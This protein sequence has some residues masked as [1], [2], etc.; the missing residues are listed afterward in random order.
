MLATQEGTYY[1]ERVSTHNVKQVLN[2]K[3]AI[4][5]ALK[6]QIDKKGFSIVE[7]LTN[8]PTNWH[9][10]PQDSLKYIEEKVI[11]YYPLGIFKDKDAEVKNA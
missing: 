7:V 8:C 9:M 10:S 6:N 4:K 11:L 5:K 1:A 2:A 3:R